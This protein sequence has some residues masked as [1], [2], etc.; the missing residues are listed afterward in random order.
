MH[1]DFQGILAR[2]TQMTKAINLAAILK[3]HGGGRINKCI[4]GSFCHLVARVGTMQC[5]FS[6]VATQLANCP[7][8]MI[9]NHHLFADAYIQVTTLT[10]QSLLFISAIIKAIF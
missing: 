3:P 7:Q 10:K 6:G 8:N 1:K 2:A 9:I 5:S 4:G